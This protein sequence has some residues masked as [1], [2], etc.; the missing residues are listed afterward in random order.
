MTPEALEVAQLHAAY[1]H[2]VDRRDGAAVAALFAPDAVISVEGMDPV[3]GP[4]AFAAFAERSPRG[5][6]VIGFPHLDADGTAHTAYTFTAART[7][8]IM[9]GYYHD[10]FAR[11]GTG[12]LVYAARTI[13]MPVHWSPQP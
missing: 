1:A 6:H 7:G 13:S 3:S 5:V 10:E 2:A 8:R 11:D 9:S 4:A 12:R